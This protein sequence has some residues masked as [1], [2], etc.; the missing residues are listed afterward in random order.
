MR[1]IF[2]NP[3]RFTRILLSPLLWWAIIAI[4]LGVIWGV[5]DLYL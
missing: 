2:L 1:L 3:P 4:C 5:H